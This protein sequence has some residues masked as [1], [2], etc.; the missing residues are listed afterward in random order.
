MRS[1]L[2]H[3]AEDACF[4]AKAQVALDL[5]RAFDAHL[6]C[7][8]AVPY[9]YGV[10]GD[11]YGAYLAGILP[12]VREAGSQFR[13]ACEQRLAAEDVTWNWLEDDGPPHE[14]LL[15]QSALNDLVVIGSREPLQMGASTLAGHLA[16]KARAPIMIVPEHAKGLDCSASAVVGWNGSAEAAHALKMAVPLL[17]RAS[18]VV[19][20][21]VGGETPDPLALPAVE[22]A[23]YLS[24]HGV[25][26][27]VTDFPQEGRSVAQVLA[28]AATAREAAYLVIGAYGV[29]RMLETAFGGVTRELF[30]KPPLPVLTCH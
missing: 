27:T 3:I 13:Q 20:A 17:R 22:A 16:L 24:R 5:A 2:L 23:E 4:E 14:R 6:T 25:T 7:L 12:T 8:Q 30:G 29:P 26:C 19:L 10:P 15:R 18:S 21:T 28:A 1:I 9:P 11:I